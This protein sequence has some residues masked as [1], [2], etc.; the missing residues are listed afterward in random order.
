VL[1]WATTH[2][3]TVAMNTLTFRV[4]PYERRHKRDLLRLTQNEDRLHI[5][6]D[7]NSIDEWIGEPGMPI[8]LAWYDRR[9]VGVIGAAPPLQGS[10]WIRLIALAR[11]VDID[12][13]LGVLWQSLTAHLRQLDVHDIAILILWPWIRPHMERLGFTFRDSIVTLRRDGPEVPEALPTEVKTRLS[14]WREVDLAIDVDHR[15]FAP[16]WQ[17][18]PSALRQ[19]ARTAA[20]FTLAEIDGQVVAYEISTLYRDGAHLARLATVPEMQGK[21]I[22]GT[23]LTGMIRSFLRRDIRSVTVNTQKTNTQSLNLYQRYG[24]QFTGLNMDVWTIEI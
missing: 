6:L 1:Y 11:D 9:L 13:T 20:R 17:L 12:A 5:H 4:V 14:D 15:A 10:T 16:I 2:V 21:G 23:L 3:S 24:F 18:T 19:A 8:Y 22:G 7:W